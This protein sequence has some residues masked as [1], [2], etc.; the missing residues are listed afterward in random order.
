MIRAKI[1]KALLLAIA[2]AWWIETGGTPLRGQQAS[3]KELIAVLDLDIQGATKEQ[4]AALTDKLREELLKTG[5]FTL[6][7]RSQLNAVLDEQALQQTGCTSQECA[8]QVGRVLGIRKI[9]TGKLTKVGENLWQVSTLMLDVETA[10]T[11]RAESV[12]HE[13]SFVGLLTGGSAELAAKLSGVAAPSDLSATA[14]GPGEVNLSWQ[15]VPGADSYNLYYSRRAGVTRQTGTPVRWV[16]SPFTHSGLAEGTTYYYVVTAVTAAGESAESAET[17]ATT[18]VAEATPPPPPPAI[19]ERGEP[20]TWPRMMGTIF[21]I[22]AGI[23]QVRALGEVSDAEQDAQQAE[24][25]DDAE[26]Y[27]EALDKRAAAE[28]QQRVAIGL[29][30]LALLFFIIQGA[31]GDDG[32][33]QGDG[34]SEYLIARGIGLELTPTSIMGGYTVRW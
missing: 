23:V 8:V 20:T 30:G 31:G 3:K 4:G 14:A 25:E 27:Q 9:V 28:D 12:L 24:Q 11:L 19:V 16:V 22:T 26:L 21:L 18:S 5:R 6:V 1:G 13:G 17:S 34:G 7:D 10:E 29:A 2:A 15:T 33:A 32:T